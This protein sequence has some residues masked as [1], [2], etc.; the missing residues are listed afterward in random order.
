MQ[1]PDDINHPSARVAG[2]ADGEPNTQ[3]NAGEIT[4]QAQDTARHA[5]GQAQDKL[6]EQLN[7]RT[8]QAAAKITEQASDMRSV[9]EAL[10]DQGKHG[11]AEAADRIAGYA[12]SVGG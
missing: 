3:T 6:H 7:E 11:P 9:S 8:S 10:R 12:E 1:M 2:D 4:G 5:A